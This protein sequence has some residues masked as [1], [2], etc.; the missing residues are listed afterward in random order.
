MA[1]Q[2]ATG[3]DSV[4]YSFKR[5][6]N[7]TIS[8]MNLPALDWGSGVW[9]RVTNVQ[10]MRKNYV[11]RFVSEPNLFPDVQIADDVIQTIRGAIAAIYQHVG[12]PVPSWAPDDTDRGWQGQSGGGVDATVIR[13]GEDLNGDN[14]IRVCFVRDG[15]E[16]T[17]DILPA[18]ADWNRYVDQLIGSIRVP[19]S[20][21]RVYEGEALLCARD[22]N[23]RG[24]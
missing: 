10:S 18:G 16:Y 8:R 17:S 4:S 13:A 11:H 14:A 23:M 7:D 19:I 12:R 15:V 5:N 3:D 20:E 1:C 22:L 2:D 6:L 24:A 21:V 9:Q